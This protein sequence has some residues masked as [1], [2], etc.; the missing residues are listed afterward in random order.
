MD[1]GILKNRQAE[2]SEEQFYHTGLD[3]WHAAVSYMSSVLS[4]YG[5]SWQ[6]ENNKEEFQGWRCFWSLTSLTTSRAEI[7]CFERSVEKLLL[8]SWSASV[9]Q[10][11]E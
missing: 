11:P 7:S 5:R 10:L 2:E 4:E 1:T 9:T 3:E 6:E 8:I